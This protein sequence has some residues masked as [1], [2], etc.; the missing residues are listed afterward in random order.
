MRVDEKASP[1]EH[2]LIR[3]PC[4]FLDAQKTLYLLS[5]YASCFPKIGYDFRADAVSEE[6]WRKAEDGHGEVWACAE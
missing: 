3:A 4:V 6:Q 1:N 2:S 5:I